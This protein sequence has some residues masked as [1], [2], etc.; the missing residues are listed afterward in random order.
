MG[1]YEHF[2]KYPYPNKN[3]NVNLKWQLI[4]SKLVPRNETDIWQ[5]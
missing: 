1:Q 5:N 4:I 3:S 2:K